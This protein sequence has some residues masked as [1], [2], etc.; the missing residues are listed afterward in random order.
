MKPCCDD[1][2]KGKKCKSEQKKWVDIYKKSA[3]SVKVPFRGLGE[4]K[5]KPKGCKSKELHA[6]TL[7]GKKFN[8]AGPGTC[9]TQRNKRGDKPITYADQCAKLHDHWYNKKDASRVQIKRA[10]DDFVKCVKA[11]PNYR[12]GDSVNKKI[13]T[14]VFAGKRKL[15]GFG[16]NPLRGTDSKKKVWK[17]KRED[18][19]HANVKWEGK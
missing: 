2:R 14:S 16:L 19:V 4:S 7:T 13:M 10:D 17:G 6:R 18:R 5:P 12:L 9:F 1:C 8:F 15:E 3:D 11:S